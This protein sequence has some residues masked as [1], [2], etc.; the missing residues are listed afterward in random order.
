[1][2][3]FFLFLFLF[4]AVE[5]FCHF[6]TDGFCLTK[7]R[8]NLEFRS[9][10]EVL[11]PGV[12]ERESIEQILSQPFT[13]LAGGGS[14]Y[15][16]ESR[17]GKYVLKLFKHHHLD[18][19]PWLQRF[20]IPSGVRNALE[21][22]EKKR[23]RI[24]ASCK[25]AFEQ[26]RDLTGLV[27]VQ[28]NKQKKIH[29]PLLLIDKLG[30]Q[31]EIPSHEVE[32]LLQKKA[33]MAYSHIDR[34]MMKQDLEGAREALVQLSSLMHEVARRGFKDLDPNVETN[35]GFVENQAVK[36]DVGPF[37]PG[38]TKRPANRLKKWLK[39]HYPQLLIDERK[40]ASHSQREERR[41]A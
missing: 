40:D 25:S 13:Y 28:L 9:E 3:K 38:V 26:M 19:L 14:C 23:E 15:V 41:S 11:L 1:M 2:W 30:I 21:K 10:W 18:P 7:V 6:Q 4:F 16:F 35:F 5:R 27:F 20:P 22:R 8:S 29:T 33:E 36:I 12:E 17:D 37:V 32:F 39:I 31:Y 34:L 24:F